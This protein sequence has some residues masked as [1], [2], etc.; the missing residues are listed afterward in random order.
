MI[1][2]EVTVPVVISSARAGR[3]RRSRSIRQSAEIASPTLA[4]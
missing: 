4:A 3:S 2:A 1:A